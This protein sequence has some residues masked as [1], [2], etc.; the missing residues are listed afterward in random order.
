MTTALEVTT[1]EPALEDEGIPG[2]P[3]VYSTR[4]PPLP[5]LRMRESRE[6]VHRAVLRAKGIDPDLVPSPSAGAGAGAGSSSSSSS[7]SAKSNPADR[8]DAPSLLPAIA[9]AASDPTPLDRA[10]IES[11]LPKSRRLGGGG[12]GDFTRGVGADR[13]LRVAHEV[14]AVRRERRRVLRDAARDIED[15]PSRGPT[16]GTRHGHD[17]DDSYSN[18]ADERRLALY[19]PL[20]GDADARRAGSYANGSKSSF[21]CSPAAV[22]VA[23]AADARAAAKTA[24]RDRRV[25]A[26]EREVRRLADARNAERDRRRRLESDLAAAR[27]DRDRLASESARAPRAAASHASALARLRDAHAARLDEVD[28]EEERGRAYS[29]IADRLREGARVAKSGVETVKATL[30]DAEADVAACRA[31]AEEAETARKRAAEALE[32]IKARYLERANGWKRNVDVAKAERD[33]SAERLR[34]ARAADR[35]RRN[36]L[37]RERAARETRQNTMRDVTHATREAVAEREAAEA[38][39]RAALARLATAVRLDKPETRAPEDIVDALRESKACR[40]DTAAKI[41]RLQRREQETWRRLAAEKAALR[42]ARL[43]LASARRRDGPRSSERRRGERGTSRVERTSR[44]SAS[45]LGSVFGSSSASGDPDANVIVGAAFGSADAD[46]PTTRESEMEDKL[47]AAEKTLGASFRRFRGAMERLA[48]LDEGLRKIDDMIDRVTRPGSGFVGSV[49]DRVDRSAFGGGN[50]APRRRSACAAGDFPSSP[51]E[52]E[53]NRRG[54]SRTKALRRRS[55]PSSPVAE[56]IDDDEDEDEDERRLEEER[57][58][59]SGSDPRASVSNTPGS[60]PVSTASRRR[61]PPPPPLPPPR[62]SSFGGDEVLRRYASR[63]TPARLDATL[64]R[65][66]DVLRAIPSAGRLARPSVALGVRSVGNG[67][68]GVP[69]DHPLAGLG[70]RLGRVAAFAGEVDD[71]PARM[72][73]KRGRAYREMAMKW[74]F[75]A[76][77]PIA[78]EGSDEELVAGDDGVLRFGD[79]G[80]ERGAGAETAGGLASA[81]ELARAADKGLG[82]AAIRKMVA[83]AKKAETVP[84]RS[85]LK[86]ASERAAAKSAAKAARATQR[87]ARAEE[88]EDE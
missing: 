44:V 48:T 15:E 51:A 71:D 50:A 30:A 32:W 22:H 70:H 16:T 20:D 55:L 84:T 45:T 5:R 4:C 6:I 28:A 64:R 13:H 74:C 38:R 59:G 11:L 67:G 34:D 7:S 85:D 68:V 9:I 62:A 83:R 35:A 31:Y 2:G 33:A 57:D 41:E 88:D 47:S 81:A 17:R 37:E 53:R 3:G 26:A 80:G 42:T 77:R 43:G 14:A 58:P 10:E 25:I 61:P 78:D 52:A 69:A 39:C 12:G 86:R 8:P 65:L 19:A 46:E 66:R 75:R 63:L 18:G 76:G 73:L 82:A 56:S 87:A 1:G 21:S 36:R 29:Q 24:A 60:G 40:E 54:D 27:D 23:A 79:E 72:K 49:D